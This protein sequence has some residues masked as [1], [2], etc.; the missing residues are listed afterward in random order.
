MGSTLPS[1]GYT[2]LI[3]GYNN[4]MRAANITTVE[5]AAMFAAQLGHESVGLKYMEEIADGSAYEGRRDLGNTQPG[6]GRRFKGRG[7]IQLTGRANYRAFTQWARD[8][9]HTTI[10]FEREPH[11][12]SEP[13]W[14]FLAASYYWTVAR[15]QINSLCDRRDLD[16]VTRAINGGTN[17]LADRRARYQRALTYGTRLLPGDTPV[18][19]TKYEKILPYPRDQVAQDTY[20]NCGPAS[21]QTIIRAA[22]G[23]F[24]T[25]RELGG[26]LGTTT[27]GT[28]WIGSFP[29]VL[30]DY[31]KD[32][33]YKSVEMPNDP[34]TGAQKDRLWRDIVASI[35]AGN[36]VVANIVA[37][38]SNYPRAVWPSTIHPAYKGGTV[39]HYVALMGYGENT[40]GTRRVW[41]ADSGFPPYGYWV[42]FNQLA[43]LIPPK[44][45][46]YSTAPA[47]TPPATPKET[48]VSSTRVIL[49]G[50][51][52]TK[53]NRIENHVTL[54]ADQ[55]LGWPK[56]DKGEYLIS[57]WDFDTIVESA[58]K[59]Q[60]EG[61]GLTLVELVAMLQYQN[62][63]IVDAVKKNNESVTHLLEAYKAGVK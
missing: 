1:G 59:K 29:G 48:P 61:K 10:D 57:G 17:G 34:P 44:G 13:H 40:D 35:D 51:S 24:Y 60:A 41:V 26:R 18:P 15:P 6:D 9:G 3:D 33:K 55:L 46:A 37:P 52:A 56:N 45:Y 54:V 20:Y 12:L 49:G 39:Y 28:N 36:G 62:S 50:E 19:K 53:L 11:R 63:L 23:L 25:E 4:A 31:I 43:T 7:P 14:G 47:K 5:R 8:Q 42:D 21:C 58:Q 2:R 16:G 38:P 32:A 22:T 30:N 27:N